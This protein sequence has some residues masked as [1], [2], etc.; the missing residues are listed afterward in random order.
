MTIS[1]HALAAGKL[2]AALKDNTRRYELQ[3]LGD[4]WK[5]IGLAADVALLFRLAKGIEARGKE[6]R[7]VDWING[8][9][10]KQ[11]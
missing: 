6:A 7:I 2:A 11:G 8:I 4:E 9:T 5:G 10:V 1:T 3:V